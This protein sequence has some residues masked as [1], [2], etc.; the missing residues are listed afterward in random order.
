MKYNIASLFAGV[1][2][3]CLGFKRASTNFNLTVANEID[4]NAVKTYKANFNHSLIE[5]DIEKILEPQIFREEQ[6]FIRN[7]YLNITS[8]EPLSYE[9]KELKK[10]KEAYDELKKNYLT[11]V[12]ANGNI[13]EF[14][15]GKEDKILKRIS[16]T[17]LDAVKQEIENRI[18]SDLYEELS[19]EYI[20]EKINEYSNKRSELL[21]EKID[22]ITAGFPCQAFSIAGEQ[23]GFNDHRGNLFYSVINYV[24]QLEA[25]HNNKPRILFL[26]NV[27]NLYSH[28][29]GRTFLKIKEE[30]ENTGYKIKAEVLNTY[31]YTS[32]PQNRERI[33]II[34]FLNE[35][36]YEKFSFDNLKKHSKKNEEELRIEI[37][38]V[39]EIENED[40]YNQYS[41]TREKYPNYYNDEINLDRD[42]KEDHQFYQL[43]RGQYIRKN[44]SG[45]CPTLT[46]NM[47]T[48]GHNVPLI[49][50]SHGVRK[51]SPAECF[52]LQGFDVKNGRY[53]LPGI[54][55][56]SLYK[57]AGNA[58]SV[59]LIEL[60]AKEIYQVLKNT[61]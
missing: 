34:C 45:V 43:R 18:V 38:N 14:I 61:K 27:K 31:E 54:S 8:R 49:L 6:E 2:G 25:S 58:V 28:D 60:L 20:E 55:N 26:E 36:D 39:L 7:K 53:I 46:A 1:G 23:K 12:Y 51:L 9:I 30:L 57:Q 56:G 24:K 52:N 48:G 10:Y 22:I 33:F 11:K 44:M 35:E 47:G 3:I 5:G 17:N 29:K 15:L 32:L 40:F 19:D 16:Y 13:C 50:T 4:E 41:Y 59:S 37:E 42:I 21:K